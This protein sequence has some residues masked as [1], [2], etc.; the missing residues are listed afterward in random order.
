MLCQLSYRRVTSLTTRRHRNGL[1]V[2]DGLH[3]EEF[4][5]SIFAAL[6]AK[7]RLL[8]TTEG[9]HGIE[10]ASIDVHLT[11]AQLTR[12]F[13]RLFFAA[14]PD[15][16]RES[17]GRIVGDRD[18]LFLRVVGD[19][20]EDR[21]ED[22]LLGDGHVVANVRK[23]RGPDVVTL[24]QSFRR[25]DAT[26]QEPR[27]FVDA[28]RDVVANALLLGRANEWAKHARARD[29]VGGRQPFG[30]RDR[31]VLDFGESR[32]WHH[33]P[34]QRRAGL[35]GV[36]VGREDTAANGRWEVRVVEDDVGRLA[37]QL[38]GDALD[39]LRGELH[40]ALAGARRSG[41]GHHVGLRMRHQGFADDGSETGHH[42][43]HTLRQAHFVDDVREDECI[44]RRYLARLEY[45]RA[46]GRQC[47]GH[48]ERYLIQRVVPRCDRGHD[49]GGLAQ[50]RGVAELLFP[51]K[52][53]RPGPVLGE[54]HRRQT[55]LDALGE[56]EWH[57]HL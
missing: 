24:L 26:A 46:T 39:R 44:D 41:E 21:T 6:S 20:G 13:D 49:A 28:L 11:G 10:G 55:D 22:L 5:E 42:V 51:L 53:R 56:H 12:D 15:A 33:H 37:T 48:L 52:L 4:F 34:S 35:T 17:I 31:E 57:S 38:E 40:D 19:D 47:R 3:L 2:L 29:R 25:L 8:V 9:R 27:A 36:H 50:Q 23:D 43:E 54:R 1:A 14:G 16:A 32:T 18:G 7:A 45:H 30:S